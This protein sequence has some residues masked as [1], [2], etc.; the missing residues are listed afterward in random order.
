MP[1]LCIL[2]PSTLNYKGHLHS[3]K[4]FTSI[5]SDL[6]I[7]IHWDTEFLEVE[8]RKKTPSF[9]L[10]IFL[11][12]SHWAL[13][14]HLDSALPGQ[15]TPRGVKLPGPASRIWKPLPVCLLLGEGDLDLLRTADSKEEWAHQ[16]LATSWHERSWQYSQ[17]TLCSMND[18]RPFSQPKNQ[19]S[20]HIICIKIISLNYV[21][22]KYK[23][24][25][26]PIYLLLQ[27]FLLNTRKKYCGKAPS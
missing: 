20:A 2:N 16:A 24:Q 11:Q 26:I 17:K 1:L 8:T 19:L 14:L 6:K 22:L 13:T 21:L 15:V 3:E 12:D 10:W 9:P 25:T 4:Y 18:L 23:L 5:E 7:P 27:W